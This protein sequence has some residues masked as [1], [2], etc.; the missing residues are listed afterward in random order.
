ML[1]EETEKHIRKLH[2]VM[3]LKNTPLETGFD[4]LIGF[5]LIA[6]AQMASLTGE[7][8]HISRNLEMAG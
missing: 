4:L 1:Y 6:M 5:V 3:P 8:G 2:A 7:R